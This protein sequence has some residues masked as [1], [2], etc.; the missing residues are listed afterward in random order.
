MKVV[1]LLGLLV[2]VIGIVD[3]IAGIVFL[4]QGFSKQDWMLTA[5]KDEKISIEATGVKS[6]IA[7]GL[8]NSPEKAQL[9]A[10]T[11][12]SHRHTIAPS[13]K[14]LL[15]T[16]KYDPT[17]PTQLTYAQAMNLENYLYLAVLGFGV[18]TIVLGIGAFMI[19]TGAAL[20]LTGFMLVRIAKA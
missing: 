13:Y 4:Q 15:G 10:D 20:G 11:V 9:A 19:I 1:K 3:V 18:I 2:A 7:S 12:R 16:G 6:D 8:I 14:D 17:N 5:M